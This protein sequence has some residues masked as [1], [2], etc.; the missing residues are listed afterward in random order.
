MIAGGESLG[1]LQSGAAALADVLPNG[2]LQTLPKESHHLSPA[3][4]AAALTPFL[5]R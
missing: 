2:Q 1:F 5:D 4:T 3:P